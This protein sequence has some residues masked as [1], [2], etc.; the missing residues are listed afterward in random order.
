MSILLAFV[1]VLG[2]KG[3]FV[4]NFQTPVS[5]QS[6]AKGPPDPRLIAEWHKGALDFLSRVSMGD[7]TMLKL[8]PSILPPAPPAA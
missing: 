7:E 6:G 4:A 1:A 5:L 8:P 2:K 3:K